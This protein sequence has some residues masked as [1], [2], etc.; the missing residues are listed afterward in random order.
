MNMLKIA[1]DRGNVDVRVGPPIG[2]THVKG[3]RIQPLC[4]DLGIK[5]APALV[6]FVEKGGRYKPVLDGVV[7]LTRSAPKLQQAIA[8]RQAR[9]GVKAPGQQGSNEERCRRRE[10]A[11]LAA[12]IRDRFPGCPTEE[13]KFIAARARRIGAG[14]RSRPGKVSDPVREAITAHV[15]HAY[16]EYD[17]FRDRFIALIQ[18]R[19]QVNDILRG[20]V[21]P[22]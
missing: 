14:E 8:R 9:P 15:R 18:T 5:Y 2:Y 6:G 3:Q 10:A 7:V 21:R 19:S 22:A 17:K 12:K 1:N 16:T 4:R 11:R 13:V 20:W